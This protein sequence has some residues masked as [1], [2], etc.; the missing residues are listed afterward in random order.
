MSKLDKIEWI[1][2]KEGNEYRGL[3]GQAAT[4]EQTWYGRILDMCL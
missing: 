2:V 4:A 1:L 3:R